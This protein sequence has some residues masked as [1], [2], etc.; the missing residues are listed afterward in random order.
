MSFSRPT[1]DTIYGRMKADLFARFDTSNWLTRGLA[2]VLLAVFAG[3]IY[4]CYGFLV[5]VSKQFIFATANDEFLDWWRRLYG[6]EDKNGTKAQGVVQFSGTNGTPITA[7]TEI[8]TDNN[9]VFTTD[10]LATISGVTASADIT[11]EAVGEDYNLD[12]ADYST[13]TL[14]SPISGIDDTQ[15]ILTYPTGGTEAETRAELINRLLQRVQNPPGSGNI[16]DYQRWALSIDGVG[17]AWTLDAEDWFGAGTV[18][19]VI[20]TASLE[21]VSTAVKNDVE[22]YI[23]SVRPIGADVSY[24]DIEPKENLVEI[25]ITPN[26]T[27]F[28]DACDLAL[29]DVYYLES[30]PGYT[31]PINAIRAAIE[32]TGVDDYAIREIL[33]DGTPQNNLLVDGHMERSG[34]TD[35]AVWRSATLTKETPNQT[36]DPTPSGGAQVLRVQENGQSTPG[37]YQNVLTVGQRVTITGWARGDGGTGEPVIGETGVIWDGTTSNE[38]QRVNATWVASSTQLTLFNYAASGY[39]EFDI[40]IAV[41]DEQTP[42]I[43]DVTSQGLETNRFNSADYYTL[44]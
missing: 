32:S 36:L 9:L 8:Q 42:E 3:A 6:L 5:E 43:S 1:L 40:V 38:W 12:P 30:G 11:A 44:N 41:S 23:E 33:I 14:V 13:L 10:A 16:A 31:V 25:S 24:V 2:L 4:L 34:V 29:A 15:L 39:A 27:D 21:V 37:A 17:R 22:T 28:Q 18:G 35:W 26:T 7:G 20:S 19:V